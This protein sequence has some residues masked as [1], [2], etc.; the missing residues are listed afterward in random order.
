VSLGSRF[1]S[2]REW[3]FH[4]S[5]PWPCSIVLTTIAD[6]VLLEDYFQNFSTYGHLDRVRI[7]A[8]PD[9]KTPRSAYERCASLTTRGLRVFCPSPDEQDAHLRRIG[10]PPEEIPRNSDNHRNVGYCSQGKSSSSS[11]MPAISCATRGIVPE[12]AV[13]AHGFVFEMVAYYV[14]LF[15]TT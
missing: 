4:L 13:A 15:E 11:Q 5:L 10:F 7:F 1:H 9:C 12:R 6:P 8:I 2:S 3:I 14:G